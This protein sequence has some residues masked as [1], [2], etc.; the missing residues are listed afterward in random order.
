MN[1]SNLGLPDGL[2][3]YVSWTYSSSGFYAC[4][5]IWNKVVKTSRLPMIVCPL[6]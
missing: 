6:N 5:R 4:K 3:V 2:V 1:Y